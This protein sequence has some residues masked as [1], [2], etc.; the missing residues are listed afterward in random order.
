M[1][2]ISTLAIPELAEGV[3][4]CWEDDLKS[5]ALLYPEGMILLDRSMSNLLQHC[6]GT[7]T[8][9]EILAQMKSDNSAPYNRQCVLQ[10]IGEVVNIGLLR[11][12]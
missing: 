10:N 1:N 4:V 9:E 5:F 12:K 6:D 8:I 11:L 7:Q 3:R 2:K